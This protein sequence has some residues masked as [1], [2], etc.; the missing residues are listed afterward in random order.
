MQAIGL[1]LV[2]LLVALAGF[3]A[4]LS[5]DSQA[6]A[7]LARA[8][9]AIGGDVEITKVQALSCA[10]TVTRAIGDHQISGEITLD[11]QLPDKLLRTETISPMGDS[12]LIINEQG[13]NGDTLLRS[14]KTVNTPPGAIIRT[15]PPPAP[16]SEAE[17]QALRNSRAELA[18]LMAVMLL[19]SSSSVPIEFTY[20][21]EAES[22]DGRADV[23]DLKGAAGFTAKLFLDKSSHRPLMLAYRGV[24]PRMAVQTQAVHG[25]PDPARAERLQGPPPAPDI[26]DIQ[27]FVDGY[28]AVEGVM[29]PHHITRA[30]DGQTNEEMTCKTIKVNPAFKADTFVR[31]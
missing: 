24:A 10:G 18:R 9:A 19:S 2:S 22:P 15:P 21:G 23:L 13:V 28:K 27:M 31:K 4:E 29:L 17:A 8:R 11:L 14:M 12:A 6:A 7:L 30:V 3:V 26:V 25:A 20:G 5:G 16:G 1:I